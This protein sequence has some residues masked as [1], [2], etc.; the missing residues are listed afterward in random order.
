[1]NN[2][3]FLTI[4][5]E[6]VL[7]I[8]LHGRNT[9]PPKV[10]E[11][12][13]KVMVD[14]F[15][16][17]VNYVVCPFPHVSH[18]FCMNQI[19]SSTID[20]LSLKPDYYFFIDSDCI[21]LQEN[22]FNMFYDL[23]KNKVTVA[24]QAWQS[25]HKKGPNG[26]IPHAYASQAFLWFARDLYNKLGR[27][28]CDHWSEAAGEEFGGDTAERITYAA[29]RRGYNVSLFYPSHV[30]EEGYDLDNGCKYG[31]GNAY[32]DNLMY[33]VSRQDDPRSQDLFV[34]KCQDVLDGKF[35]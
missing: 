18:G 31:L 5:D 32:G 34:N 9:R 15:H 12:H 26:G 28:D 6:R 11:Y 21:I 35:K 19:I 2:F 27:P 1:M 23:V 24:G 4:N 10:L 22:V 30:F 8:T 14:Y 33:H 29:K 3:Q 13:K 25:N 20:D 16:L 7:I 17:P